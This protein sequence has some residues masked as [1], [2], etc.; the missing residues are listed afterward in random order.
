MK[1][2]FVENPKTSLPMAEIVTNNILS[3]EEMTVLEGGRDTCVV[4]T[5]CE[6]CPSLEGKRH[7]TGY[8]TDVIKCGDYGMFLYGDAPII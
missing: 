7:C 1:Y 3:P 4:L 2:K 6:G 5:L 8:K